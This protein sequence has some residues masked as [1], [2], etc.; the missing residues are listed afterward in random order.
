MI[1]FEDS[2][3][4]NKL[5]L[6]PKGIDQVA[7]VSQK[8]D[9][10]CIPIEYSREEPLKLELRHFAE[11]VAA[12][13]PPISG[14]KNGIKVLEILERAQAKLEEKEARQIGQELSV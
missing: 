5:L 1:V 13:K 10:D 9:L 2:R 12:G 3:Q 4:E 8:R 6:C 14:A 7:G 11:C